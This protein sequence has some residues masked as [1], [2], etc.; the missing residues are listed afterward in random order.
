MTDALTR[1]LDNFYTA[2]F[3]QGTAKK[4]NT[5]ISKVAQSTETLPLAEESLVVNYG[6]K[7]S[8]AY[9]D[10]II[11]G[12]D[13]AQM[14]GSYQVSSGTR[15][16]YGSGILSPTVGGAVVRFRTQFNSGTPGNKYLISWRRVE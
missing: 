7:R 11:T 10:L 15:V 14:D 1:L 12:V 8:R 16:E 9:A 6:L 13:G 5:P 2:V 4:F 3:Q